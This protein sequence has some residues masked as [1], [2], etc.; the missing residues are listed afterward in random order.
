VNKLENG[1]QI[2][3]TLP[4]EMYATLKEIARKK[5]I[6]TRA[7]IRMTLKNYIDTELKR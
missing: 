1:T 4:E 3:L 2:S 5:E 6:P 7:L